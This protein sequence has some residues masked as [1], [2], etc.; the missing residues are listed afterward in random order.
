MSDAPVRAAGEPACHLAYL[1]AN[2]LWNFSIDALNFRNM[3]RLDPGVPRVDI[4][5]AISRVRPFT[6]SDEADIAALLRCAAAAPWLRVRRV[7]WKGNRGRDFSSAEACLTALARE[8]ADDD[9]VLLRNRSAYGPFAAGWYRAYIDQYRRHPGTG[10]VGNTINLSG[11]PGLAPDEDG[12][13]VQTYL[14]LSQWRHLAP[15]A[16]DFPGNRCSDNA[17][18]IRSGELGLSRYMLSVGLCLSCLN[19]PERAFAAA[20]PDDPQLPR[21]DVKSAA[22]QLPFRYKFPDY[23]RRRAAMLQRAAWVIGA[24]WPFGR[25]PL[26]EATEVLHV[27]D[28]D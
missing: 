24:R 22:T 26:A 1:T 6:R 12:R 4:S 25:A 11:P 20:T 3:A 27:R 21:G 23:R 19:W 28:Y 9:F 2:D 5:I 14:Y 15:L 10:L 17:S 18:A 16:H 13:H 7:I 8:A